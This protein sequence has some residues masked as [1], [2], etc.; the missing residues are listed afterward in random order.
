[1][2][3]NKGVSFISLIVTIIIIIILAAISTPM[4]SSVIHDSLVEDAK[5]ELRNVE[6]VIDYAR[7]QIMVDKF[8]PN[9]AYVI[10]SDELQSKFG[11]VL[12]Q[13]EINHIN[14]VNRSGDITDKYFLMNQKR[15]DS[16]FGNNFNVSGIREDREYL[17]SYLDGLVIANSNGAKITNGN[18][19]SIVPASAIERGEIT[20]T[21][22]PNGN[23]DWRKSQTTI[24]KFWWKDGTATVDKVSYCWSESYSQPSESK[25]TQSIGSVTNNYSEEISLAD[26]TGNSWYLWVKVDYKETVNNTVSQ[27]KYFRSE[28]FFLDNIPPTAE[29]KVDEIK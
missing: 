15:F 17:I 8:V 12:T 19:D 3:Y 6:N 20:V 18:A 13:E 1:M 7:A 14:D 5:A 9:S 21:F 26:E 11:T 4:L 22:T 27:T 23:A 16:E 25:F 10:D 28:A 2:K 29:W 24:A